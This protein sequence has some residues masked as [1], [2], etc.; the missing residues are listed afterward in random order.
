MI[1]GFSVDQS[2]RDKSVKMAIGIN[3]YVMDKIDLKI[4]KFSKHRNFDIWLAV[5]EH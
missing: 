1:N 2:G 3:G 4:F 5:I